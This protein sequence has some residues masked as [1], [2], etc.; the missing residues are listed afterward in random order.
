M[1]F[2]RKNEIPNFIEFFK[3]IGQTIHDAYKDGRKKD[4]LCGR[5]A[6]HFF[7]DDSKASILKIYRLIQQAIKIE[8][9]LKPDSTI[10]TKPVHEK[11]VATEKKPLRESK[12]F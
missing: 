10:A 5:A 3:S 2:A 9:R 4:G 7:G 6:I 8:D 1:V 11:P 12:K